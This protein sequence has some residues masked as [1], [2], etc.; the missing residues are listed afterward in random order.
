MTERQA[1]LDLNRRIY[2]AVCPLNEAETSISHSEV[3]WLLP[4]SK[5]SYLM[6][7]A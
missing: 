1:R 6:N 7:R 3:S 2:C 4:M 5:P